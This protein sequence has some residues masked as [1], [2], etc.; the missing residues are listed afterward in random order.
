MTTDRCGRF[1]VRALTVVFV[2]CIHFGKAIAAY[3]HHRLRSYGSA[4]CS[5]TLYSWIFHHVLSASSAYVSHWKGNTR[6]SSPIA[7]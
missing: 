6:H 4:W 7:L 2:P 1:H 5:C 3:R